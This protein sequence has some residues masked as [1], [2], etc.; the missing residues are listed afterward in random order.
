MKLKLKRCKYCG[1]LFRKQHNREMYCSAECR[2]MAHQDQCRDN[3]RKMRRLTRDGER[4]S[5]GVGIVICML[6]LVG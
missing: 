3:M 5:T 6:V 2:K 4:V 1:K